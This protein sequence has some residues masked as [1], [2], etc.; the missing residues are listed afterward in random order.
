MTALTMAY[1]LGF[2]ADELAFSEQIR[3][4][5]NKVVSR[6]AN[7]IYMFLNLGMGQTTQETDEQFNLVIE[8]ANKSLEKIL[9]Q[10]PEL[11]AKV[12]L[13]ID[14]VNDAINVVQVGDSKYTEFAPVESLLNLAMGLSEQMAFSFRQTRKQIENSNINVLALAKTIDLL[15]EL[16][17]NC[18]ILYKKLDELFERMQIRDAMTE[19]PLKVSGIRELDALN[20]L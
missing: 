12:D 16:E 1:G 8:S 7:E 19:A 4:K 13:S 3:A 10:F 14:R 15:R 5:A 2:S 11:I 9:R 20:E 18:L 6:I 17:D